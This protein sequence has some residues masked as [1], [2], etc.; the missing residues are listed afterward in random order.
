ML[1]RLLKS[2]GMKEVKTVVDAY[3]H[4]GGMAKKTNSIIGQRDSNQ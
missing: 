3:P 4:D 2:F 1:S